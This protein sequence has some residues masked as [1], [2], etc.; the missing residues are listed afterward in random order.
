M[1]CPFCGSDGS[2]VKDSRP[3]DSG[4]SIRRRRSCTS[5]SSR[6]TTFERVHLRKLVVLKRNGLRQDFDHKKLHHSIQ[7]AVSKGNIE[8]TTLEALT[9][10]IT[11]SLLNSGEN[12]IKSS[13]IGTMVVEHLRQIDNVGYIRYASVYHNFKGTKDFEEILKEIASPQFNNRNAAE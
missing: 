2:R 8:A 7:V 9:S 11:R 3:T 13:Q 6:F 5:C 4:L 12:E 10:T 1:H